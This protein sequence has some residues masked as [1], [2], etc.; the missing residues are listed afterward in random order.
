MINKT[1]PFPRWYNYFLKRGEETQVFWKQYLEST[2]R[3]VLFVMSQGFDPR[4]CYGVDTI[5]KLG[6]LG[7]RDCM[8]IDFDEGA[9]SSSK[10]YSGLVE[11]N[12]KWLYGI[13]PQSKKITKSVPMLSPEGRR[14]GSRNIANAFSGFE[15]FK[16]YSDIIIDISA[17]PRA[18]YFPLVGRIL[19]IMDSLK[20]NTGLKNPNVHLMVSE[21][22]QLDTQI[23]DQGID[24]DPSYVYGF[25]GALGTE[26]YS[27]APRIWIP[28]LGEKQ[29]R[30]LERIHSLVLPHEICPMLPM[31]SVN[32]R[33]TDDL[34]VE[35]RDLLFDNWRVD[36]RN[37]MYV[38][39]QN[40]FEAYRAI[41]NTVLHYN[42]SLKA[43][44]GCQVII[45]ALSSKLL[46]I[47][48]LLSAYEL[49]NYGLGVGVAT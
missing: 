24:D 3:N 40:P 29:T 27:S 6:G 2:S 16:G 33:R 28:L 20:K 11:T 25:T 19:F 49:K 34:I 37:F 15:E 1:I 42:E 17:M 4:M 47:G 10:K 23:N 8:V 48:A 7:T 45:S 41:H 36:Q 21:N 31:P 43:L 46:S 14:V 5:S 22:A 30:Q 38:A 44:G 9:A 26:S 32:P 18:I 39:E 35:Y 12:R 13:F